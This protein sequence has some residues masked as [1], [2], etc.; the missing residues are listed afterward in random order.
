VDVMS[1]G[2]KH[3]VERQAAMHTL[4]F[5][6]LSQREVAMKL[7]A[8]LLNLLKGAQA[9]VESLEGAEECCIRL[10]PKL[11]VICMSPNSLLGLTVLRRLRQRGFS[12]ALLAV[13]PATDPGLILRA[14]KD[15]ANM[16]LDQA[17]IS[18]ELDTC[19][20]RLLRRSEITEIP[21]RVLA[22][23]SVSGGCGATTLA[24]NLAAILAKE[25]GRCNL[26]D[27]NLGGGDLAALL[28]VRP[29]FTLADACRNEERLDA[30]MYEKMLAYHSSGIHLLASPCQLDSVRAITAHGMTQALD[31]A[32][33][34]FAEVV[35]DLEDCF[36][37]DQALA[38]Q[39][40]TG[41]LL[42]CRL[43][44]ASLRNARRVARQLDT[45]EIP[46]HRVKF[47]VNRFGQPNELPVDDAE[48]ALAERFAGLIPEDAK[49]I[50]G[51]NNTGLPAVLKEPSSK[52]AQ[53]IR[54]LAKVKFDKPR[55]EKAKGTM[56]NGKLDAQ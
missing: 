53:A 5:A 37:A 51:A 30:A 24:V 12:G 29:Q 28:D 47:V 9:S 3:P 44:F 17:E 35:V 42:V 43:D 50:N 56:A 7:L 31:I 33:R 19:L 48:N 46:R 6:D 34:L 11:A 4:I 16:F 40:A 49:T 27:L 36:H 15:G 55:G 10:K 26:I 52:V 1:N 23:L 32:S 38:L 21:G 14:Q 25:R 39:H 2:V 54:Q 22:V 45:L 13:G 8:T 20:C 41:I 18:V